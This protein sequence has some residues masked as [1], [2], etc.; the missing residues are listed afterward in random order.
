MDLAFGAGT[1]VESRRLEPRPFNTAIGRY[2]T[3]ARA[4]LCVVPRVAG[5]GKGNPSITRDYRELGARKRR[6][7]L[8]GASG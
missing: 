3:I 4:D 2:R 7:R 1:D 5:D 6:E 8:N